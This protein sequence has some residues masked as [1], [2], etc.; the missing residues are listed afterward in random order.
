[1]DNETLRNKP[2]IVTILK[3]I[4]K[5]KWV[6]I[7]IIIFLLFIGYKAF[8]TQFAIKMQKMQASMPSSVEVVQIKAHDV[9]KGFEFSGRVEAK[10][11]VDLVARVQGFLQKSYLK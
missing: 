3:N 10:Y 6:I 4:F 8:M 2:K 5:N 7:G 11:S 9:K 1:M